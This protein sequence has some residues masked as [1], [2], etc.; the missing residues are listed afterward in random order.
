MKLPFPENKDIKEPGPERKRMDVLFEFFVSWTEDDF[1]FDVF[2]GFLSVVLVGLIWLTLSN[3]EVRHLLFIAT[4][5][6]LGVVVG[7]FTLATVGLCIKKLI[8]KL[9]REKDYC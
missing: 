3:S 9:T 1:G 7:I 2:R 4:L 8:R 6:I 5:S